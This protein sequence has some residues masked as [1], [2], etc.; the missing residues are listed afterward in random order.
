MLGVD[1]QIWF[2]QISSVGRVLD[3]EFGAGAVSE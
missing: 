3:D 2:G 1:E